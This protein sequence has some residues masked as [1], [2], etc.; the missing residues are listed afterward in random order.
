MPKQAE[1]RE[2]DEGQRSALGMEGFGEFWQAAGLHEGRGKRISRRLVHPGRQSA[3]SLSP[4]SKRNLFWPRLV[5]PALLDWPE[6]VR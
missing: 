5:H 2:E 1:A 3:T 6:P 4:S